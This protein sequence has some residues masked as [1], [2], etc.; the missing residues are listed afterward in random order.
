MNAVG[1]DDCMICGLAWM[2]I[3]AKRC[4]GWIYM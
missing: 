3:C 2:E 4:F 1:D